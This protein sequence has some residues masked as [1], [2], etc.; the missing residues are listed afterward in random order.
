MNEQMKIKIT[1]SNSFCFAWW[2][3]ILYFASALSSY[4]LA[5][6]T[7]FLSFI[8]FNKFNLFLP[9]HVHVWSTVQTTSFMC[10]CI[11][12]SMLNT[13]QC[14]VDKDMLPWK[15]NSLWFFSSIFFAVVTDICSSNFT[16]HFKKICEKWNGENR[17]L[18]Y[19]HTRYAHTRIILVHEC[20]KK[21]ASNMYFI[22]KDENCATFSHE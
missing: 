6:A 14:P 1:I 19:A 21:C 17:R 10:V 12:L 4:A 16:A 5:F 11:N 20:G 3:I 18:W 2:H 13:G 7:Y 8:L 15:N 22:Y 9:F